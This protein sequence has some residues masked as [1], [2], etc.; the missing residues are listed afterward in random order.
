[1]K[2]SNVLGVGIS[3]ILKARDCQNIVPSAIHLTG[4]NRGERGE[5]I[6]AT[7][8]YRAARFR[9]TEDKRRFVDILCSQGVDYTMRLYSIRHRSDLARFLARLIREREFYREHP[10]TDVSGGE[11]HMLLNEHR[12]VILEFCEW[13]GR[14]WTK[15]I[16]NISEAT[17][18]NLEMQT[19]KVEYRKTTHAGRAEVKA[20]TALQTSEDLEKKVISLEQRIETLAESNR[21]NLR[22]IRELERLFSEFVE[23]TSNQISK[24]LII[25]LLRVL[26]QFEGELPEQVDQLSIQRLINQCQRCLARGKIA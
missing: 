6:M 22:A 16:F 11:K 9:S 17:L 21:E 26:I 19:P 25:P 4:I 14:Q 20:D 23:S 7:N 3:G 24:A 2:H 12:S 8:L 18:C 10:L 5:E 1:M 15:D 13:F